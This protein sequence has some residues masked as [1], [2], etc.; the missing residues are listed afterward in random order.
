MEEFDLG[1]ME[2]LKGLSPLPGFG[3]T[4]SVCGGVTGSIIALG[5]YFGS[6]DISD[7]KSNQSAMN[8]ARR[9]VSLFQEEVG[10]ILCPEIQEDVIFGKYMDPRASKENA[11]AFGEADARERCAL[12]PGIGARLAAQ[13]IIES[14]EAELSG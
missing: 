2:L 4:G 8:A 7:H 11:K 14:M 9:F 1:N 13:I 10:S 3:M 6:D 12:L 5:L